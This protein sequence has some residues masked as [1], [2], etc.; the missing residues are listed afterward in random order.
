MR[1]GVGVSGVENRGE[2]VVSSG[3]NVGVIDGGGIVAGSPMGFSE[4]SGKT[5]HIVSYS[6]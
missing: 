1:M 2:G 3:E 6:G 4:S 5:T